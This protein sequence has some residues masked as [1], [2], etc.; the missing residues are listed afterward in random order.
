VDSQN[1]S[2]FLTVLTVTSDVAVRADFKSL[3]TNRDFQRFLF[4]DG[5]FF[6]LYDFLNFSATDTSLVLFHT[7]KATTFVHKCRRQAVFYVRFCVV[8]DCVQSPPLLTQ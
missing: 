3:R 7:H 1:V 8:R 5:R 6:T 4:S 2:R